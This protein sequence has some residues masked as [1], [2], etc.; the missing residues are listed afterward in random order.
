MIGSKN[1]QGSKTLNK[2]INLIA[3]RTTPAADG[4]EI[5]SSSTF[6]FW[7]AL[8]RTPRRVLAVHR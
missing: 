7:V 8:V 6:P 3:K 2:S 1:E 4:V 5:I